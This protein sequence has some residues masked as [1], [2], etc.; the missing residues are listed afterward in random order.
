MIYECD[1]ISV[2]ITRVDVRHYNVFFYDVSKVVEYVSQYVS[3]MPYFHNSHNKKIFGSDFL[4][5]DWE[6]GTCK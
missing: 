2:H 1:F 6:V 4:S 3:H 5:E